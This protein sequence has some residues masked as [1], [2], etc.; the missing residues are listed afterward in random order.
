MQVIFIGIC[1]TGVLFF[2]GIKEMLPLSFDIVCMVDRE[3]MLISY[4]QN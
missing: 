2:G 1:V 4:Y 3:R